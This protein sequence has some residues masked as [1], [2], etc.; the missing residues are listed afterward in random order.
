MPQQVID[1][2]FKTAKVFFDQPL[3]KKSEIHYKK[4]KVLH[5]YEPMAE[6]QTDESKKA[7]LNEAF[8][9]GYEVALDPEGDKTE[10]AGWSPSSVNVQCVLTPGSCRKRQ[11]HGR[12]K[13]LARHG[14]VQRERSCILWGDVDA[15]PTPRAPPR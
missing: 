15:G 13:C 2:I 8:N 7:D 3:E 10:G 14:W 6:V 1:N 12:P 11:S 9:C 4:S 5:G